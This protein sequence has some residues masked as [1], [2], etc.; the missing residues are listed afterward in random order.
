MHRAS[1][2]WRLG[3]VALHNR[4]ITFVTLRLSTIALIILLQIIN[5]LVCMASTFQVLLFIDVSHSRLVCV[6]TD[7]IARTE[8]A[9]MTQISFV[10]ISVVFE[11][12]VRRKK[13]HK[14]EEASVAVENVNVLDCA[15]NNEECDSY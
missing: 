4:S 9:P 13:L 15:V 14:D 10:E 12:R 7:K 1:N 6:C 11:Y 5:S 3:F 8:D 2:R